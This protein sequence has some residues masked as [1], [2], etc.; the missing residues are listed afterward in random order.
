MAAAEGP[1]KYN[2]TERLPPTVLQPTEAKKWTR[3]AVAF[4]A[5]PS[6][7]LLLLAAISV[8]DLWS[9]LRIYW[10]GGTNQVLAVIR[11]LLFAALLSYGVELLLLPLF[12][13][14]ERIGWRRWVAYVPTAALAGVFLA[15]G[16]ELPRV[17]THYWAYY[18]LFSVAGAACAAVFSMALGQRRLHDQGN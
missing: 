12:V 11:L 2:P 15:I 3:F 16:L 8:F 6:G 14:Y 4:A 10:F 17:G 5:A 7:G 9:K 13:V 18:A 1:R